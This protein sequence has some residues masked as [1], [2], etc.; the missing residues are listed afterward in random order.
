M[1]LVRTTR[2]EVQSNRRIVR[3]GFRFLLAMSLCL[4]AVAIA[5]ADP[6]TLTGGTFTAFQDFGFWHNQANA[7][8]PNI[9]ISGGAFNN[10]DVGSCPNPFILSSLL[11]PIGTAG[12]V[13][14]NGVSYDAFV[15]GFSFTDTTITG[16]ISVFA[17]RNPGSPFLFS[18]S[19]IGQGFLTVT[20]N[21]EFDSTLSVFTIT[22]PT[23][24][25]ASL[26]LIGL[27]VSGLAVKL[28]NSR[29]RRNLADV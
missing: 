27:G 9:S 2:S 25:P 24:E 3:I 10:C 6:L 21:P 17:D 18:V 7:G 20:E 16:D 26:F 22:T 14:I 15:A 5:H 19:F 8:G 11:T 29:R 23:P 13:T 12:S 28:K 4:S 1:K